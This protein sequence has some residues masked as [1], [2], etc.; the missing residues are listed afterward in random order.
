MGS[1]LSVS[2]ASASVDAFDESSSNSSSRTAS[3][4]NM[5]MRLHRV[6]GRLFLNCSSQVASLFCKQGRKGINQD[7]MLL[8][9]NFSSNKD[10][11]FCG[12]FDGHGPH[13]HMVAKKLRDS[14]PLKLIA[15]WNLL[16]PNNNS[17]S[18]NNSDTPCAVAPGNIGT[19]RD[20]FV[21]ACKVMDRELKVQHQIDCSCSGSTGLTLLKQGQDLV[22]ANVGDSRAVLATQDR[23]NGSLVAVQLSTDHKPHLPREAERIRICKGRVFSIKNESGIPRVWLP[24]IDSPGLAMSRAFGDFC[25]KDFG[26][27]S[28]P[29]FSYHRLTQRDQFVWDVLS[30]EEAVAII[31]SAPRSSAARMLVE[32]AIHAW[33]TKL[34]LTKVDDCSVVCLFFH[35]DSDSDSLRLE[36]QQNHQ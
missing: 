30:N 17:S 19:L 26:V 13:G 20:S 24:N 7:A 1:C 18:N 23:S 10:T 29:D 33:K 2:G 3:D 9:D 16:H 21:K 36:P 12:V 32:A 35:S 5:E 27:I 31:S 14:F 11:V 34:P 6:P 15:Q 25:L 4:Y 28:V 8:W 22:I